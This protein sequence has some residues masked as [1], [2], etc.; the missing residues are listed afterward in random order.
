M[1]AIDSNESE[2]CLRRKRAAIYMRGW[3]ARNKDRLSKK[4]RE[5]WA[6]LS[7]TAR[8][9]KRAQQRVRCNRYHAK[10]RSAVNERAKQKNWYYDKVAA[11]AKRR[12]YYVR[13]S[14]KVAICSARGRAAAA[15]L[16]FDLTCPWYE[17]ELLKGCAVTGLPLEKNGSKSPWTAHVDRIIPKAGYTKVNCRL[18]CATYNLAKKHWTDGDVLRM[19]LALV[20]RHSAQ[21]SDS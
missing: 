5:L 7:E 18:V 16:P 11:V 14:T 12:R 13:N 10:N 15:G 8:E 1:T 2:E 19:A 17:A 9:R 6:T 4:R 3:N 21:T 20:N